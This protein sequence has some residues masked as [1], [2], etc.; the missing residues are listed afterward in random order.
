MFLL[1]VFRIPYFPSSP[2]ENPG[3]WGKYAYTFSV[4]NK[5]EEK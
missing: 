4:W 2:E 1:Y 3:H 5:G